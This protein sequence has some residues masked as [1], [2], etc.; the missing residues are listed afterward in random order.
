[1]NFRMP[2]DM[3]LQYRLELANYRACLRTGDLQG[4]W[5][6]LERAHI[7]GQYHPVPHTAMHWR[8]L[9]MGFRTGSAKEILGQLLRMSVGWFGSLLNRIP[10]GNTGRASVQILAPMPIPE[11]LR[12]LLVRADTE[13]RGFLACGPDFL[14]G[15]RPR[16]F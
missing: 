6:F 2:E 7:V 15:K 5:R 10:V 14:A 16:P 11:D 13:S 12:G 3:L 1:M 4:A 8:M 9:C